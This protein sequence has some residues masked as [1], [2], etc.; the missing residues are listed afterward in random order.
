[1]RCYAHN[2]G[3]SHFHRREALAFAF[4]FIPLTLS[5]RGAALELPSIRVEWK[6]VSAPS[7]PSIPSEPPALP[8]IPVP[9]I[10][11]SVEQR[12]ANELSAYRR[13]LA[14][15]SKQL[16]KIVNE[17]Q[18]FDDKVFIYT[19]ITSY[20]SPTQ[21][22]SLLASLAQLSPVI[23]EKGPQLAADCRRALGE[24]QTATRAGDLAAQKSAV[25]AMSKALEASFEELQKKDGSVK[26][27]P[28]KEIGNGS[29]LGLL[30]PTK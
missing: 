29:F 26:I 12:A 4:S 11:Q 7:M 23:G 13:P 22:P 9:E 10:L 30:P 2:S 3:S 14:D 15:M 5:Q 28:P 21:R 17:P 6:E 8:E 25:A 24:L 27:P 20:F 16:D 1:M 19:S 18:E